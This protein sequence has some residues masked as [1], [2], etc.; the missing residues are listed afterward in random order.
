MRKKV[1][2]VART[3]REKSRSRKEAD[4]F[5]SEKQRESRRIRVIFANS[6]G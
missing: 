5:N 6:E 2:S 4:K 1:I 3:G